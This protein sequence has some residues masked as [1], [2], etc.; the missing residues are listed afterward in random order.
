VWPWTERQKYLSRNGALLFR[1][2][3]HGRYGKAVRQRSETLANHGWGP[4][5]SSAG[6]GFSASEWLSGARPKSLD[7]D[8]IDHLARYCAFRS[9]H[10][11]SSGIPPGELEHMAQINLQ[12]SLGVSYQIKLQ[13]ERPV[14]ADARMMP[15]EWVRVRNGHLQKL[16]AADHGENHFFPGPTDIAWDVAGAIVE[17]KLDSAVA[18][19]F[20][21]KYRRIAHDAVEKRI[22]DYLIAY[23]CFRMAFTH[24]A[25]NS[26]ADASEKLRLQREAATYK[27]ALLKLLERSAVAP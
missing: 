11:R 14:I 22:S 4:Q 6:H 16:D 24:T 1:F 15:Y 9:E 19:A 25:A 23:S 13:V 7:G 27:I 5:I 21:D 26:T 18:E 10:L 12:R 20:I 17:W 8:T 3:G 2:D